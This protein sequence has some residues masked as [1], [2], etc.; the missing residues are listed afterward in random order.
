[1]DRKSDGK[2][3]T[4]R[5][6]RRSPEPLSAG[7]VVCPKCKGTGWLTG[8]NEWEI[9]CDKC[10]GAGKLDWVERIM[11]KPAPKPRTLQGNWSMEMEKDM[12]CLY[13]LNLHQEVSDAMAKELAKEIDEEIMENI[14]EFSVTK[15]KLG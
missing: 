11:G 7:D 3:E 12:I 4:P 13:D 15:S 6:S 9:Y 14:I 5:T 1:M 2:K 10:Y 8:K